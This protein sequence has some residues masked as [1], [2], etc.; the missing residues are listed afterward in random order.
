MVLPVLIVSDAL[1]EIELLRS[2]L[3]SNGVENP[4]TVAKSGYEALRYLSG[5]PE[6][7][8]RKTH[9]LPGVVILD[10]YLPTPGALFILTWQETEAELKEMLC[11]VMVRPDDH[12]GIRQAHEFGAKWCLVKPLRPSE[13]D[14][15]IQAFPKYWTK[16][17]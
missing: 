4:L 15:L 11:V 13:I 7:A 3:R 1:D 16:S 12:T 5:E 6:F 14:D 8:D 17:K 9:P 2:L 10:L